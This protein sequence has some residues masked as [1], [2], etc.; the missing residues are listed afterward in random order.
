VVVRGLDVSISVA[1]EAAVMAVVVIDAD[2]WLEGEAAAKVKAV[3]D[4]AARR[5]I[6]AR[7]SVML[8]V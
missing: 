8:C 4:V 7:W 2:R 1:A 3:L 6:K 5:R